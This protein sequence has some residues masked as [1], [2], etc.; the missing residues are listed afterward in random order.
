MRITREQMFM[1]IARVVSLRSTCHRLN[2]G[3]IVVVD[4]NIISMGYN[5]SPPG[6]L[7]CQGNQCPLSSGGCI[8]TIHAEA[9]AL[10]RV[11]KDL[12]TVAKEIYITHSP[13]VNCADLII[14]NNVKKVFYEVPYRKLDAIDTLLAN[15][16]LVFQHTPSGYL[17]DHFT[18]KIHSP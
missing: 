16:V 7:H 6:Q 8:K 11:P 18:G 4:K 3:A 9:N 14:S 15:H 5:G 10:S 1:S 17:I 13:C 12:L 2:V